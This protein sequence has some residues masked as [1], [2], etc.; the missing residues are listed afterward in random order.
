MMAPEGWPELMSTPEWQS[1]CTWQ[2][3]AMLEGPEHA[4][5]RLLLLLRPHLRTPKIWA[6]APTPLE[7]PADECGTLV[8]RNVSWLGEDEQTALLKWLDT[9]RRQVI[10]TTV[11]PLFPLIARGRFRE[12]LYYRLNVVVL[13]ADSTAGRLREPLLRCEHA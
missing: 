5:E 6:R 9:D 11:R 3:N 8:L 2:H 12:A 4:T 1:L 10:S 7:L 13:S